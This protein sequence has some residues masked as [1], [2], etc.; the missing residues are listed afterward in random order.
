MQI[1][2]LLQLAADQLG[3]PVESITM[4]SRWKEDLGADSA[5]IML[6]IMDMEDATGVTFDDEAIT[7]MQTVG[8]AV[9][10]LEAHM[11]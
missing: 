10:Y 1:E 6:M 3:V 11:A 4:E 5:S 9:A 7:G 2:H 8:D